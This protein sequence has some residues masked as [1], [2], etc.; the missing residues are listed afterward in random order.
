MG[1]QQH[2]ADGG[3]VGEQHDQTVDA[4]ALPRGR[5]QAVFQ[6]AYI[7][8]VVVH[9]LIVTGVFFPHL[10]LEAFGLI[11]GVVKLRETVGQLAA[12]HEELKP[13]GH[14]G[15]GIHSPRQG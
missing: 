7:V 3:G 1:E 14:L 2:V 10:L 4:Y 5:R 12:T 9:G 13:L 8:R 6:G 11:F 15:L